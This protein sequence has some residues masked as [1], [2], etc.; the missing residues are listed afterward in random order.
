MGVKG[1]IASEK[2]VMQGFG[3]VRM[4]K[5]FPAQGVEPLQVFVAIVNTR[6]GFGFQFAVSNRGEC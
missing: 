5:A 1:S 6:A 3:A 4:L 2:Y